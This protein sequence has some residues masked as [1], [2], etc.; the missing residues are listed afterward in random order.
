ML[1]NMYTTGKNSRYFTLAPVSV[2]LASLHVSES[3][4]GIVAVM[5]FNLVF[6]ISPSESGI[7]GFQPNLSL[8]L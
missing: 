7:G 6:T 4:V 2:L 8:G 5:S 1:H 3:R